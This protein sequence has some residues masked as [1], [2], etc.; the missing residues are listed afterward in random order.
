MSEK[1][2]NISRRHA[3]GLL[4]APLVLLSS[5]GASASSVGEVTEMRGSAFAEV[6]SGTRTMNPGAPVNIDELIRTGEASRLKM[7]LAGQTRVSLSERAKIRIDKFL[8]ESGG[9]ITIE[10]GALL[11]DKSERLKRGGVRV[12]SPYALIA[13]RGTTFFAGPSNGVF[14]IFV[15][16]GSVAVRAGGKQVI[17][18]PGEGTDIAAIGDAP[19]QPKAWG[20]GRVASALA[21]V[22]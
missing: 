21:S 9:D 12:N 22:A 10:A 4:A 16:H 18:K 1:T 5:A 11:F 15:Q 6:G 17:L 13:V 7:V 8:A 20:A 19:T 2:G 14:G 3:A